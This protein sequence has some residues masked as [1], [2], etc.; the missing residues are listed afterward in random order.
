M[1][2]S[3]DGAVPPFA[4]WLR[5]ARRDLAAAD[6]LHATGHHEWAC[7]C[8]LQAA[9]KAQKAIYHALEIDPPRVQGR[10]GHDL[11]LLAK[12]WGSGVNAQPELATA[13]SYL[14]QLSEST[15][16]PQPVHGRYVAPCDI[17]RETDSEKAI[18]HARKLVEF[19]EPLARKAATFWRSATQS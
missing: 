10:P 11:N 3:V 8:A 19:C 1:T 16:Y 14:N 15:R 6:S 7:F 4:V 5:Q 2:E 9:E 17:Y 13:Q 12:G 18:V